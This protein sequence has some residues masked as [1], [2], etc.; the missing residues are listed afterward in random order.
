MKV[1]NQ[2][3]QIL[4]YVFIFV[5]FAIII[6]VGYV[7]VNKGE[8]YIK[9][10]YELWTRNIPVSTQRGKIYDRNGK[11]IVGNKL[12]PTLSIIPKQVKDKTYTINALA[13]ILKVPK[14]ELEPHF[15]KHV[16]VEIIKPAGKNIDLETAKK[17]IAADLPGVYVASDVVRYYPYGKTLAHVLGIVGADNQGITG[18]EYIYDDLLMGTPGSQNI[19]TD[20]HGNRYPNLTGDYTPA[21]SGF[22]L[23]LTIDIEIQQTLERVLNNA[24]LMYAPEELI[25]LVMNPKTSEILAMACRPTFDPAN[26]QEYDQEI[27]NRNLP[28][29]KSYEPGSTYKIVTFATGIEER[30]F[31]PLEHFYCSGFL[32]V[33]GTRIRD[34]KPAGH[35]DQTFVQVLQNSCNPGFMTIGLRLGKEKLFRYIADFGFGEKTGVDLLG[36]STGIIFDINKIGNVELANAAFGQGNTVTALQLLNATN[37]AVNGGVLN[38]PYVLKGLGIPG[39]N[40][41]VFQNKTKFVRRVVSPETSLIVADALEQAVAY[42][43]PRGAYIEGHRV[44]G[45]TGQA[46]IPIGGVYVPGKYILS[47]TGI[48][49][50]NDPQISV[51]LAMNQPKS[52]IQFAGILMAPMVKEILLDA[53]SVLNLP[54]QPGQYEREPRWYVDNFF[55]LVENYIGMNRK[56]ITFHPYY[57]IRI[58]GDGNIIIAQSPEPGEKIVQDGYVT[59]YTD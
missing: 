52:A 40:T 56:S 38:T 57:R 43:T 9:R 26:Y 18:L 50:M 1:I 55:Y 22:D 5:F 31:Q 6:R 35:G 2:R 12:A 27:F 34:W 7:Q 47:F 20:A 45:K 59:L 54:K 15:Q 25:G 29:W 3:I 44:G 10:A 33:D 24:D 11:L 13:T 16:A 23:Y 14:A 32:V 21:N 46:E 28:I 4:V 51:Y 37:A 8:E 49:P 36:E 58:V 41:L 30:A 17:V 19:Y 53:I 42:G 39:T 48:T